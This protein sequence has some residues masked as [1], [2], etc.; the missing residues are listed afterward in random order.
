MIPRDRLL[1]DDFAARRDGAKPIDNRRALSND[2]CQ[3]ILEEYRWLITIICVILLYNTTIYALN[4]T[5]ETKF[6]GQIAIVDIPA[7]LESSIAIHSIRKSVENI[8][9]K[10]H[11]TLLQKDLEFKEIESQLLAKRSTL[12]EAAFNEEVDNFN[13]KVNAARKQLQERKLVL[14]HSHS[15]A[16]GKVQQA[17]LNIIST[18]AEKHNIDIVISNTQI[19]FAKNTLNITLEVVA[20]LNNSLK[21]VPITYE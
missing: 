19:L 13:Q 10:M 5:N 17:I 16:V 9:K 21:Q 11:Q 15:E 12:S 7:V 1:S 8:S 18:L 20:E 2:V 4:P 3:F 14:A 6:L